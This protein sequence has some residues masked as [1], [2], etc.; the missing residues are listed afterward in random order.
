MPRLLIRARRLNAWAKALAGETT[1]SLTVL[2]ALAMIP[3]LGFIGLGIE[4]GMAVTNK[5]RLDNAADAAA[6]S[7]VVTAKAYVAANANQP[8]VI[9]AALIAGQNQAIKVFNINA[10]EVPLTAVSLVPPQLQ[11]NGQT[12]T[13]TLTYTATVQNTFGKLFMHPTTPLGNTIVAKADLASYLD[14][15]LM[16]D[17]SGSMGLPS[18][19]LGM[20]ALARD[21]HDMWFD[22]QQGCQFACHFVNTNGWNLAAGK[23]QLRSDAVNN[24]VCA[25][26]K[27][28]SVQVVPNQYRIGIYPFINDLVTLVP[29]NDTSASLNALKAAA[30]CTS[31]WPLA[32][33]KLLDTGT[34]QFYTNGDPGTG[35]GSGGTH[36]ENALPRMRQTIKTI[37]DGTSSKNSKPF[38]FLITDGMQNYQTYSTV[39]NGRYA[40]AGNPSEFKWYGPSSFDGSK[41]AAIDPRY[42]DDLKRSGIII[43][44]LYIPYITINYK[45]NHG[46]I[47]EE[48]GKVNKIS[49]T[50]SNP[51]RACAS[52][53]YFYTANTPEDITASLN[54]MFEHALK[55]VRLSK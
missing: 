11:R 30:D 3:I 32:F 40:Y 42:C 13:V 1:G 51:L 38:V 16:V 19:E 12:L 34:T 17:V 21:N 9:D 20:Q 7:A 8:G 39:K 47:S 50:L 29:L 10:G 22:Y 26:L 24:A 45:P 4:Y 33:T 5:T 23:I 46:Y 48:N 27:R 18:T 53:D 35:T 2:A 43:S 52:P 15:Y 44:I 28:A 14:F 54:A 49:P 6:L 36:F 25:L 55:G 31:S 37:G 41:P